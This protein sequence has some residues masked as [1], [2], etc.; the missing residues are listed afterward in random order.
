M[1]LNL[2]IWRQKNPK[3]K[4]KMV[5]YKI[6]NV[7]PDMS[8]LEMLDVVPEKNKLSYCPSRAVND[9]LLE[10]FYFTFLGKIIHKD[11]PYLIRTVSGL[12]KGYKLDH[13]EH[14]YQKSYNY[15]QKKIL[16]KIKNKKDYKTLN[17]KFNQ[18]FKKRLILLK[19]L[20]KKSTQLN[21]NFF[22]TNIRSIFYFK[23]KLYFFFISL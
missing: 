3:H 7:S 22:I 4:G 17:D 18:F 1:D 9:E 10:S 11:Y 13:F 16:N 5:D 21:S 8:F 23:I 2:K 14:G 20:E 19:S 6:S 12:E 15:L